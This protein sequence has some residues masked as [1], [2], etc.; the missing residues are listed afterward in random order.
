MS[1]L[2]EFRQ[3]TSQRPR[4]RSDAV[5]RPCEV[6]IFPGVRIERHD[7]DLAHRLIDSAGSGDF[8]GLGGNRPRKSS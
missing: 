6:V 1:T 7:V 5:A 4:V 8:D 2:L 3:A